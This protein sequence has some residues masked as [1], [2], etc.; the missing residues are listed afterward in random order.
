MATSL[1]ACGSRTAESAQQHRRSG[2]TLIE[3][4][5]VLF[6]ISVL[7]SLLLPAVQSA[8]T[9]MQATACQ[10]NIRQVDMALR[11]CIG[12]T[13]EFPEPNRWSVAILKWME[14]WPLADEMSGN[15]DPDAEFPRPRLFRCPMQDDFSSRVPGVGFCHY[16]LTVDRPIRVKAER[17]RWEITDRELLSEDEQQEPWYIAP[18][19][20][21]DAQQQLFATKPGPHPPGLYMTGSGSYPR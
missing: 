10:N 8:R 7:L 3:L 18:E 14:E 12:T 20:T 21:F 1:L 4:L 15:N 19:L 13:K 9:K 11:G 6:I 16:V 17:V 2:L 5:A